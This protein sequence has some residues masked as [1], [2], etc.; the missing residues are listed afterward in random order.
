MSK[1]V[2][3]TILQQL[4]GNRFISMTGA[5]NFTHKDNSLMF[6]L[7][8]KAKNDINFIKITLNGL[9][10]YDVEYYHLNKKTFDKTLK[11]EE[12]NIHFD[13][14]QTNFTDNTGLF[15]KL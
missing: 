11:S 4:G 9:D 15:T 1:E 2:A 6:H 12:K 13:E 7:P 14:L 5:K 3:V 10:L 8:R